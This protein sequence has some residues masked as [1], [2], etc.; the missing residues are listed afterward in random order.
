MSRKV[1]PAGWARPSGYSNGVAASGE[2]LF[3]SGQV[4]WDESQHIVSPD[5]V[6]Q[7]RRALENVVSV[8][9]AWGGTSAD[10]MRLTWYVTDLTLYRNTTAALGVVYRDVMGGHYPAMTLVQV[11]GLV[12]DG[13]LVEIEATAV[14]P[15]RK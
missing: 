11:A 7:A 6:T 5:F 4:A 15:E 13:A 9:E 8:V 2:I 12:D 1:E 14:L 10:I 3:I